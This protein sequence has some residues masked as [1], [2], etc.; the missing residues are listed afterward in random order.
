MP[1]QCDHILCTQESVWTVYAAHDLETRESTVHPLLARYP[2][3]MARACTEHVIDLLME[4]S[5]K[6]STTAQWVIKSSLRI[7]G[8]DK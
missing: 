2:M 5:K 1:D 4:D 6:L 8:D 3:P 7:N